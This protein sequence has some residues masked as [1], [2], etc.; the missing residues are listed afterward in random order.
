MTDEIKRLG[1]E[2]QEMSIND[3]EAK[4]RA[5]ESA[6][7]PPFYNPPYGSPLEVIFAWHILK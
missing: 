7:A 1:E 6:K 3:V 2:I 5:S 4:Y